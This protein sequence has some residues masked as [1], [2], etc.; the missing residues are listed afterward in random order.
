MPI[1]KREDK[2]LCQHNGGK[3]KAWLTLPQSDHG[4]LSSFSSASRTNHLCLQWAAASLSQPC[5]PCP[6][7]RWWQILRYHPQLLRS[8]AY[9]AA[10]H[11]YPS[12][13]GEERK[14]PD[15]S[16]VKN[17]ADQNKTEN[18]T[19]KRKQEQE[20]NGKPY[21]HH[22]S[23]ALGAPA[24]QKRAAASSRLP[25]CQCRAPA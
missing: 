8:T 25:D 21:L 9:V 5:N 6:L 13:L 19:D 1:K 4:N 10:Y 14:A 24:A 11:R 12:I 18:Q 7:R 2:R 16:V 23:R 20:M 22:Q 17:Q 3:S 15:V